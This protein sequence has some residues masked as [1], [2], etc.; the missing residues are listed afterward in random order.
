MDSNGN[1]YGTTR[2]GGAFGDG[3]VFE[4]A[5]GS[6]TIT[7]LASFNDTNGANPYGGLIMDSSGNLYGTT[8]DGGCGERRHGFR[9]GQGS[10]T[11][12][13]LALFNGTNG[14]SRMTA[15]I[16][17]SS[18]NLYG[19][20]WRRRPPRRGHSFRAGPRQRHDHRAGFV[21]RPADGT[22]R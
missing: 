1:L 15:L 13:T 3:T 4:L 22:T 16:M 17:D 8:S 10:G 6:G 9:A 11:I 19:T 20:R 12:T 2:V 5:K 21:Q 7:T 18:G 14:E